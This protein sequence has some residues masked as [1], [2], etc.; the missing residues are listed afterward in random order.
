VLAVVRVG[1]NQ[2]L[3]PALQLPA[4]SRLMAWPKLVIGLRGDMAAE[5]TR[6]SRL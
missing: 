4:P 2:Q 3:Q 1:I 5:L 6:R